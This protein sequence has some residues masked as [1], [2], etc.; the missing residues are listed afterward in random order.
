MKTFLRQSS[1]FLAP[2]L[3]CII[4]P[5]FIVTAQQSMYLFNPSIL[6]GVLGGL[7]CLL[8]LVGFILTAR[9]LIRIGKG[10]IMPWG[11]THKLVVRGLYRFVRN[12]M[13][14]SVIIIELGEALLF[15]SLWLGFIAVLFFLVNHVYFIFSEEP[16]L[17]KR[18][19][20]E[21][22]EY[23]KNVPRWIPRLKP[24]IRQ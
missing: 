9:L 10:T 19:G 13:I 7:V 20:Q 1:S 22:V 16:G 24:W 8:G 4:I 14:L 2:I 18:F 5:F 23:K 17:V 15:A 3:F 6:L 11:P 21:Y 12:P